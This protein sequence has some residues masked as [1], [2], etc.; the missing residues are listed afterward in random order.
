VVALLGVG[1]KAANYHEADVEV[2]QRLANLSWHLAESKRVT[3][4]LEDSLATNRALIQTI[5]DLI[6]TSRRD[7]EC[8]AVHASNSS[9]LA[10]PPERFLHR[11][12]QGVLPRRLAVQMMEAFEGALDSRATK[13]LTCSL[14]IEG[15]ER[16]FEA[17][18]VPWTADTVITIV[19]DITKKKK[20]EE[21]LQES[22]RV[23][24]ESQQIARLGSYV[25]DLS[26]GFFAS[27]QVLDEIFG[28]DEQYVR[29]VA[30]WT[31]LIHPDWQQT[32]KEYLVEEVLGKGQSFDMEYK[33]IRQNTGEER[34]VHGLGRLEFDAFGAPKKMIGTIRDITDHKRAEEEKA[35]LQGQLLQAQKMESLG[36]LAGGI[37]HDMNNVLGAIL[38]LA[39]SRL[40][41][42]PKETSSHR[43]FETIAKAAARGA[44]MVRSL[45]AFARQGQAEERDLDVNAILEEEIRLLEHTTLSR[46]RLEMDLAAKLRSIRG[47]ASALTHAFMNLCVNAVDAM[48]AQG[49][50]TLRTRN[51]DNHWIE[52]VVEDTGTGMPKAVL[53]RAMEPFYTTKGVGKG[54]GLGLAMVYRTVKAHQGQMEIHSQPG[55]GTQVRLRFPAIEPSI[56]AMATAVDVPTEKSQRSLTVLLVD[57][58]E[59]MKSAVQTILQSLGHAVFATASGEEGLVTIEAGFAPEVVILDINMPGLGGSGTLP[60]LR[61]MLPEV[62]VLLCTGRADQTALDLAKAFPLVT[63]LAKPFNYRELKQCLEGLG[64]P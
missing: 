20:A 23:L 63:L 39:S 11:K 64:R 34:W 41:A 44:E 6:F 8:L 47:D 49:T 19:R 32:M 24:R 15:M 56:D 35:L 4:A 27:S 13:E 43:A 16:H 30:G 29:S 28:I 12:I 62:P 31:A 14:P 37:A 57:D 59:L 25:T 45:L 51:V 60:R 9:F 17:R 50:L 54:T 18:V 21:A 46:V 36:T 42:Q 38:G 53:D 55:Q 58:D 2:V 52:V 22:E 40:E 26:T 1:N 33:I 3:L 7:G 5:P 10:V 48:P 61:A